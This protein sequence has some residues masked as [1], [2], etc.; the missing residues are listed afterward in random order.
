[1]QKIKSI[2]FPFFMF[3]NNI[4]SYKFF[5]KMVSNRESNVSILPFSA[6]HNKTGNLLPVPSK[7]TKINHSN[8]EGNDK[9]LCCS[10]DRTSSSC[11]H[12]LHKTTLNLNQRKNTN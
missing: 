7:S 9:F 1:M 11:N 12:E 10:Y 6:V 5:K 8:C 3:N 2:L 4:I